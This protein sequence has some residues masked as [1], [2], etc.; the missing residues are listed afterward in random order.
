LYEYRVGRIQHVPKG[1]EEVRFGDD[2]FI[3]DSICP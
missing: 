2:G 1:A 3:S